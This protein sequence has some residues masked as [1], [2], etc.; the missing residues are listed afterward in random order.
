MKIKVFLLEILFMSLLLI[1]ITQSFFQSR[2]RFQY[3]HIVAG[4]QLEL[5]LHVHG[6]PLLLSFLDMNGRLAPQKN[7]SALGPQWK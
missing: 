7:F 4:L 5:I 1:L 6:L 3:D 2:P